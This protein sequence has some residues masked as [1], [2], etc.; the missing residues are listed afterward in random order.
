MHVIDGRARRRRRRRIKGIFTISRKGKSYSPVFH[1]LHLSFDRSGSTDLTFSE[2]EGK[3]DHFP[4]QLILFDSSG[5][6]E[7]PCRWR[8]FFSNRSKERGNR[9][10]GR[11]FLFYLHLMFEEE[12]PLSRFEDRKRESD[13]SGFFPKDMMH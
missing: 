3:K 5:C 1:F 8:R 13:R 12:T 2:G 11:L 9:K 7:L 10:N 6:I 4:F